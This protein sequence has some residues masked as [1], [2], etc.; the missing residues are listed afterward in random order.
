VA[1]SGRRG[2]AKRPPAAPRACRSGP[3][4]GR[5]S[6]PS[7]L[8]APHHAVALGRRHHKGKVLPGCAGARRVAAVVVAV[9]AAGAVLAAALGR[10]PRLPCCGARRNAGQRGARARAF[11]GLLPLAPVGWLLLACALLRLVPFFLLALGSLLICGI[12]FRRSACLLRIH[13]FQSQTQPRQQALWGQR[14][15]RRL[16]ALRLLLRRGPLRQERL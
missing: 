8:A 12:C 6:A 16:R 7:C 15:R 13:L 10:L 1:A 14:Q 3:R 11:G 5:H 2:Q 9:A 4:P